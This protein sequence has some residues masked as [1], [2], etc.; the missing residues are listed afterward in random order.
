[1]S[2]PR[3]VSPPNVDNA[4]WAYELFLRARRPHVDAQMGMT[5]AGF[6]NPGQEEAAGR[7][8]PPCYGGGVRL[9][10]VQYVGTVETDCTR[11]S[12]AV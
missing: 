2:C 1:M 6:G 10:P 12:D 3:S 4:Q 7:R 9:D 8:T 11:P 5:R